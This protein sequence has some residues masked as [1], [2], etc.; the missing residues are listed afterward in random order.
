MAK[1][2]LCGGSVS[3]FRV[4]TTNWNN[5]ICLDCARELEEEDEQQED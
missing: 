5:F 2:S 1:C 4:F 3:L